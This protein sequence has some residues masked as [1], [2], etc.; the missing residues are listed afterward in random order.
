MRS[1]LVGFAGVAPKSAV[2][3]LAELF[4]AL[5]VKTPLDSKFW[6]LDILYGVGFSLFVPPLSIFIY[7]TQS[8]F[9]GSRAGPDAKEALVKAVFG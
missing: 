6:I 2:P 8:E 4:S 1:L 5:V 7:V 9:S 3:N